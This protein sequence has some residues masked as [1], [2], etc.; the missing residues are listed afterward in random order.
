MD[1]GREDQAGL[2]C[3]PVALLSLCLLP[4][5]AGADT[6]TFLS[7]DHL[8]P[9][10]LAGTFGAANV[11]PSRIVVHGFRGK[12]TKATVTVIDYHSGSPADTD[13]LLSRRKGP[14]VMLMSDVCGS[15]SLAFDSWIFDDS[16]S[17][18]LSGIGPCP[19]GEVKRFRPS[20]F[21][22][23]APEPDDLSVVGGPGTPVQE[24]AL[25]LQRRLAQRCLESLRRRR[26]RRGGF[27]F[28]Y[29]GLGFEVVDKAADRRVTRV[30]STA[31]AA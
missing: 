18:F 22:G 20:N 27:R 10:G 2:G 9:F 24:C 1:E 14:K 25:F 29:R 3:I 21:L 16:A 8:D 5:S 11:F 7:V 28:R 23:N 13:M 31:S 4:A 15:T 19:S 26:Q 17:S 6:R 12:V 30:G